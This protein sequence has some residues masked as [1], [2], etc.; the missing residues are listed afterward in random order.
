MIQIRATPEIET[1]ITCGLP[2]P[3]LSYGRA[4]AQWGQKKVAVVER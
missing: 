1:T 4:S 3:K 2:N